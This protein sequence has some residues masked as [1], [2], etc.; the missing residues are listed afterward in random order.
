MCLD[1]LTI[2][3]VV[4]GT[5]M[6]FSH[7][8]GNVIIPIDELISFRG[9][10]LTTNQI[11]S[12]QTWWSYHMSTEPWGS[13]GS[14]GFDQSCEWWNVNLVGF[15]NVFG[16]CTKQQFAIIAIILRHICTSSGYMELNNFLMHL[17]F[18]LSQRQKH[19]KGWRFCRWNL[20][21]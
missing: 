8:V 19:L 2:W 21:V 18:N 1:G 3:L 16:L 6:L 5:W 10:D 11:L 20:Y 9:V 12:K 15:S 7:S 17:C 14:V 13:A 4:T